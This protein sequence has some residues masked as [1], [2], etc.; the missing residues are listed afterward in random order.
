M[1]ALPA[2][3]RKLGHY[4]FNPNIGFKNLQPLCKPCLQC[5]CDIGK[6]GRLVC[7]TYSDTNKNQLK[8]IA[9]DCRRH[10][11]GGIPDELLGA[12]QWYWNFCVDLFARDPGQANAPA[13]ALP[14]VAVWRVTQALDDCGTA[15]ARVHEQLKSPLKLA[16]S[17]DMSLYLLQEQAA[18]R[19]LLSLQIMMQFGGATY[20]QSDVAARVGAAQPTYSRDDTKVEAL[21]RELVRLRTAETTSVSGEKPRAAMRAGLAAGTI[22]RVLADRTRQSP[23]VAVAYVGAPPIPR[24]RK[25]DDDDDGDGGGNGDG[26]GGDG[27]GGD[28]NGG[29][30][31]SGGGGA[32]P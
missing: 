5:V 8:C 7:V 29:G 19:S 27:N 18:V 13:N 20:T 31:G 4:S 14:H 9:C 3:V 22:T 28:G 32:N 15:W 30:D 16:D 12:A 26:N 6:D 10:K 17:S 11:C 1:S 21:A 24:K 2:I 25:R 23:L